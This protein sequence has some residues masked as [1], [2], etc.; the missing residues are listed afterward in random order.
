V[1]V[2][3]IL[4][5]ILQA[6]SKQIACEGL[7]KGR[8]QTIEINMSFAESEAAILQLKHSYRRRLMLWREMGESSLQ[9]QSH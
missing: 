6:Q 3:E 5:S 4:G 8:L 9:I 2:A 7:Q 1:I